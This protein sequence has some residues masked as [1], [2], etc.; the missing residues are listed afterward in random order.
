MNQ[1]TRYTATSASA[2][3][4]LAAGQVTWTRL[5]NAMGYTNTASQRVEIRAAVERTDWQKPAELTAILNAAPAR[6][7]ITF[8]LSGHSQAPYRAVAFSPGPFGRK[9]RLLGIESVSGER[10]LLLDD[11]GYEL[12]DLYTDRPTREH[13]AA[14]KVVPR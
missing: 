2:R 9:R 4:S 12:A 14:N 8:L 10:C 13:T 6:Q 7:V 5:G 11:G 3:T 1:T